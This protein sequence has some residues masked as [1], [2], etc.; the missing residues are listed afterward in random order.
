M[1]HR[2]GGE[3]AA[4]AQLAGA[5]RVPAHV[6]RGIQARGARD[7]VDAE[8]LELVVLPAVAETAGRNSGGDPDFIKS[9]MRLQEVGSKLQNIGKFQ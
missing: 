2:A 8:V 7:A 4:Q 1:P 6:G 3:A 9:M 5:Y